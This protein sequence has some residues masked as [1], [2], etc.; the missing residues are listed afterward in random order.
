MGNSLKARQYRKG[1]KG[2]KKLGKITQC[3]VCRNEFAAST[4]HF[5]VFITKELFLDEF[6]R[7]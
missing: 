3:P 6:P 5:T 4:T 2:N 1:I 7:R